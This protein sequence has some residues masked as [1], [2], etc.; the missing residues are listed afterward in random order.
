MS[1]MLSKMVGMTTY[2]LITMPEPHQ[3]QRPHCNVEMANTKVMTMA[4]P[5][6]YIA[7]GGVACQSG[8]TP[9]AMILSVIVVIARSTVNGSSVVV[10]LR[11]VIFTI[12]GT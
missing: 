1:L 10:H 9:F 8:L 4:W 5:E 2:K 11:Y 7:N 3:R 12:C 6:S